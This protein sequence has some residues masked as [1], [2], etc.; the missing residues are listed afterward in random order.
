MKEKVSIF[1]SQLFVPLYADIAS[2]PTFLLLFS[3][4]GLPTGVLGFSIFGPFGAKGEKTKLHSRGF[5]AIRWWECF[6]FAVC[7][8]GYVIVNVYEACFAVWS[9]RKLFKFQLSWRLMRYW[10]R[11]NKRKSSIKWEK[12]LSKSLQIFH[13]I[14]LLVL[15]SPTIVTLNRLF[16]HFLLAS[17]SPRCLSIYL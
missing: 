6:C 13:K 15:I 2:S 3:R 12:K 7:L 5:D 4:S 14:L 17:F 1:L 11:E 8:K 16:F 9:Q 10:L